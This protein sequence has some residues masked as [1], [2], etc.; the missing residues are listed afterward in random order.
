[1]EGVGGL[2]QYRIK[3]DLVVSYKCDKTD[4]FTIS[5]DLVRHLILIKGKDVLI[6]QKGLRL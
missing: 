4:T 5:F 1:M 2:L 3:T 6:I